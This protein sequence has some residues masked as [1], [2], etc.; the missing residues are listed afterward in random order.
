MTD[1]ASIVDVD[2]LAPE[3]AKRLEKDL[4]KKSGTISPESA[5]AL[6]DFYYRVQEHRIA[7]GNQRSSLSTTDNELIDF[8]HLQMATV[9][10]SVKP[11][12]KQYANAH[13]AGQWALS[14]YGIGDILSAGLLAHI[15]ISRVETVGQI[16]S[17]AGLNPNQKW[18]KGE[19]RPWNA[20]LKL[21]CYKIGDS[22]VKF[23][24]QDKCFYGHLYINE[25]ARRIAKNEAGD[26]ADLAKQSLETKNIKDKDLRAML[27]RGMLPAGR[28][29]LQARRYA[30]KI[31]LS[32]WFE[33]AY[34]AYN[35]KLPPKPWVLE[36]GGHAHYIQIPNI[37]EAHARAVEDSK[38]KL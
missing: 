24:K 34:F 38:P 21:L 25:K 19:K 7:L 16:W 9:E 23:H 20:D 11:A 13:I 8:Y 4:V 37:P 1:L 22:F 17:Y 31:F 28:I 30:T 2:F 18:E 12:L 26:Y 10:H 3:V 32:H 35:C 6:V 33:V 15:D 14:Q 27:E 29:D 36:H 5:R